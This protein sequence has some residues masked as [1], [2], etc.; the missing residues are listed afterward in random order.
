LTNWNLYIKKFYEKNRQGELGGFWTLICTLYHDFNAYTRLRNFRINLAL[1]ILSHIFDWSVDLGTEMEVVSN[2]PICGSSKR[3]LQFQSDDKEYG[4]SEV[5]PLFRCLGCTAAYLG[6]IP[7]P[8]E[9]AKY[10]PENYTA[11]DL[12]FGLKERILSVLISSLALRSE[13]SYFGIPLIQPKVGKNTAID[14]GCGAGFLLHFL[15][16]SGWD[17]IGLD[18]SRQAAGKA[19]ERSENVVVGEAGNP[20]FQPNS[21]DLITAS[22]VLEHLQDPVQTLNYFHRLLKDGGKL[23]VAV[24][25]FDSF[26]RYIFSEYTF[27]SLSIPRHLV[28]FNK[29]SLKFLLDKTGFSAAYIRRT[30]YPSFGASV[31]MKLRLN[32]RLIARSLAA[33]LFRLFFLPLDLFFFILGGGDGITVVAT[34]ARY[35]L[36]SK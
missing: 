7:S 9:L 27:A 13:G 16:F 24:P 29:K 33:N 22:N 20:P 6:Q 15:R 26:C 5:F 30:P 32:H 17:A 23:I 19:R 31:M 1:L 18:S 12:N 14:A 11:Y 25:N 3:V 4:S 2:C 21:I 36:N 28:H 10:Y 35:E 34:S 8:N